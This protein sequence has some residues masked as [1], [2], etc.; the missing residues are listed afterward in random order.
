MGYGQTDET[1]FNYIGG[2][3][4]NSDNR[5]VSS[6]YNGWIDLFGWGTSG[7]NSGAKAYEPWSTSTDYADYYPG[8]SSSNN[9]TGEYAY[10]DWGVYN[11]IGYDAPGTWRT[12][13]RKEWDY[14]VKTRTD[15]SLKYGAAKVNSVTGIVLL[16]DEWVLPE[17]CAFTPGMVTSD[18]KYDWEKV[19][20]SNIYTGSQWQKMEAA[21]AVFLPCAGG[22]KTFVK[23][24]GADGYI[25]TSTIGNTNKP[26]VCISKPTTLT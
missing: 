18:N 10:A 21:G 14:L 5:L 16:P 6:T 1:N 2:T 19:A 26:I 25:W 13:T 9:L 22:R 20:S 24:V 23:G 4:L 17:G 12:L 7:W 8:N 3:V 11:Q 15:A